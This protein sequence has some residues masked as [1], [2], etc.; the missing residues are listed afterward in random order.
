MRRLT[1]V[2]RPE[3]TELDRFFEPTM[4]GISTAA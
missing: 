4:Q 1:E 3:S 2:S